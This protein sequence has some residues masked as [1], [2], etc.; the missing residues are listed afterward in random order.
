MT[1]DACPRVPSTVAPLRYSQTLIGSG[2][3]TTNQTFARH[4]IAR[5]PPFSRIDLI[6]LPERPDLSGYSSSGH[7]FSLF[8]QSG[9]GIGSNGQGDA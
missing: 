4:D 6:Q 3:N 7:V 5:D 1:S 9:S 8:E 2:S